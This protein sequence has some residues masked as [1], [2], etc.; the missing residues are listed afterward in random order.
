MNE[1][2]KSVLERVLDED[3]ETISDVSNFRDADF[4]DSLKYVT[5]VVGLESEF[6]IQLTKDDVQQ[7]LSVRGIKSV[8]SRY[9][10][11]S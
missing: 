7:L 6:K 4:W 10:I 8:L 5:L 9:G 3:F 1:R 2:L 11:E